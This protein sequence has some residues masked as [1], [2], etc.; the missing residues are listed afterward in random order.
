MF[1]EMIL[2]KKITR[3][4]LIRI[5]LISVCLSVV[6]LYL[7][8]GV[9]NASDVLYNETHIEDIQNWTVDEYPSEVP[10]IVEYPD[11]TALVVLGENSG[12]IT[13]PAHN[14]TVFVKPI[15]VISNNLG[16]DLF[17]QIQILIAFCLVILT[18]HS[19]WKFTVWWMNYI[20]TKRG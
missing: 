5:I 19:M 15:P 9:V 17:L 13:F 1:E 2:K 7:F 8:F 18:I 4:S 16:N 14:S 6:T 20:K 12:T 10:I 11:Y 3:A